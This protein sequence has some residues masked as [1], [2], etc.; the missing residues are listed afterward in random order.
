MHI[1]LGLTKFPMRKI[2][3]GGKEMMVVSFKTKFRY[4]KY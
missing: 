3:Q 4:L 1:N 2:V